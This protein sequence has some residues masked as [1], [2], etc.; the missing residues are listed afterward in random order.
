M[1][2]TWYNDR[3][4]NNLREKYIFL[5]QSQGTKNSE[6]IACLTVRGSELVFCDGWDFNPPVD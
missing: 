5:P 4:A 1:G 6:L 3:R 2:F